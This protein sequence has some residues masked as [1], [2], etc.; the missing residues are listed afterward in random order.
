TQ[1]FNKY[2][3]P[4]AIS[5][6]TRN[7]NTITCHRIDCTII[8]LAFTLTGDRQLDPFAPWPPYIPAGIL[9]NQVT[10]V[11]IQHYNLSFSNRCFVRLKEF[12]DLFFFA[13]TSSGLCR[14]LALCAFLCDISASASS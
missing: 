7:N 6:I 12:A 8:A 1:Q 3:R 2:H 10:F 11:E 5:T 13:A 4:A 9:P 14:G